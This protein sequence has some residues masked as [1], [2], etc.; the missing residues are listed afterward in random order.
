MPLNEHT[1]VVGRYRTI[2]LPSVAV[3]VP[4][5]QS[6]FL[7]VTPVSD[8]FAGM[9]SRAPG[10]IILKKV[11]VRVPAFNVAPGLPHTG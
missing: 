11:V 3:D 10:A 7:F 1:P 9:G 6:L 5:G 4:A 8:M 2:E